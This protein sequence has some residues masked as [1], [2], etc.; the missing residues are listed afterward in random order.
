MSVQGLPSGELAVVAAV[1]PVDGQAND[2]PSEKAQPSQD[3]QA[4]HQEYAEEYTEHGRSQTAG[5][6]ESAMT[7]GIAEAQDDHADR[8]QDECE[9]CADVRKV[10]QG[11]DVE[12]ASGETHYEA[13]DPCCGG[14][15]T[16]TGMNLAEQLGHQTVA[17][18][19]EPDAGLTQLEHE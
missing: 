2:E 1:E 17:R 9:E 18:H 4:R 5:S 3:G 19:R 14:G 13:G 16:E 11:T 12:D 15:C 7:A 10:G 8:Y 6:S